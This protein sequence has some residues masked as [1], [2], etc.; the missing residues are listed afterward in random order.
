MKVVLNNSDTI[1]IFTS[2]ICSI[3]CFATPILFVAQ[4]GLL[5]SNI[6][7]LWWESINYIFIVLSFIAVYYSAKN[8]SENIMKPILWV[9]WLFFVSVI[10]NEMIE[11]TRIP[12]LFSYVSAF[13]LAFVHV[14]NLKYCQCQEECCKD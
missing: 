10:L 13:S 12:E 1:G 7:P 8:T 4:S 3:H 5:S 2:L 6:Q 14:Y 11:L 9:C